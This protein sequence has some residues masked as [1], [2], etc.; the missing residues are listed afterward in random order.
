MTDEGP[1][2]RREWAEVVAEASA[3]VRDRDSAV[4]AAG[5]LQKPRSRGPI[6]AA[7]AVVLAGV[8]A[9]DFY[10]LS[11]PPEPAPP[12]EE[13]V[14]LRWFVAD[15]V[16]LIEAFRDEN[17]RLPSRADLDEKLP[18]ELEYEA[19]GE[20][21]VVALAGEANRVVYDG[22]VPLA[23]WVEGAP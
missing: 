2:P 15:A 7:A 12:G 20:G 10:M 16:E 11:R 21:Y 1:Q 5:E 8:V 19:R 4:E 14:D 18:A 23:G 22:S 17:G 6:L 9:W 3:H 13:V